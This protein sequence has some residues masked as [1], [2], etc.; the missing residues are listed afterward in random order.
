MVG[1]ECPA[2]LL[3]VPPLSA[4]SHSTF[5]LSVAIIFC[6]E[7]PVLLSASESPCNDSSTLI[8]FN[9]ISKHKN[10]SIQQKPK[11]NEKR[12]QLHNTAP[13]KLGLPRES[14]SSYKKLLHIQGYLKNRNPPH[15]PT[16]CTLS[17]TF[18]GDR[19]LE[20]VLPSAKLIVR[21]SLHTRQTHTLVEL[22]NCTSHPKKLKTTTIN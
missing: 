20:K 3:Q 12:I 16:A 8:T 10:H 19:N 21:N 13:L 17:Q 6:S 4:C 11:L 18:P 1:R 9:A 2:K 7:V 15:H 14:A 5:F 22:R